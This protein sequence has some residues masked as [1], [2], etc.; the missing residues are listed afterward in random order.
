[1][2]EGTNKRHEWMGVIEEDEKRGERKREEERIKNT[3]KYKAGDIMYIY[4]IYRGSK[5]L[6]DSYRMIIYGG[7]FF[8]SITVFLVFFFL[9]DSTII[10]SS[11][12]LLGSF[13]VRLRV[14][15][16]NLSVP[17]PRF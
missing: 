2:N 10:D 9:S 13:G 1:M 6:C 3:Y 8:L 12:E 14:K 7:L 17:V 5:V 15:D 11:S 16:G 4:M